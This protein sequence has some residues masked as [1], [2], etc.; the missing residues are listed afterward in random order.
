MYTYMSV[1]ARFN[2]HVAFASHAS[3]EDILN[4]TCSFKSQLSSW[5][6]ARWEVELA[7]SLGPI[8]AM[9]I[10]SIRFNIQHGNGTPASSGA[11]S[12]RPRTHPSIAQ[13][14]PDL[15]GEPER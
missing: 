1:C 14:Q 7:F 15:G 3:Q 9:W 10:F 2:N 8:A 5:E 12:E 6:A 4:K 13:Y 11:G